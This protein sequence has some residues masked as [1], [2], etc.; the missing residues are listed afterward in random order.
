ML[1]KKSIAGLLAGIFC[2]FMLPASPISAEDAYTSDNPIVDTPEYAENFEMLMKMTDEERIAYV[3][4]NDPE[5]N[6]ENFCLLYREAVDSYPYY[7]DLYESLDYSPTFSFRFLMRDGWQYDVD[8]SPLPDILKIPESLMLALSNARTVNWEGSPFAYYNITIWLNPYQGYS[9]CDEIASFVA[10]L[11]AHPDVF[12][13]YAEYPLWDGTTTETTTSDTTPETTTLPET[14]TTLAPETTTASAAT[15][16]S[17]T[18]PSIEID[19]SRFDTLLAMDKEELCAATNPEDPDTY[20]S[21][22]E[23][24]NSTLSMYQNNQDEGDCVFQFCIPGGEAY[25]GDEEALAKLIGMPAELT[26]FLQC[27]RYATRDDVLSPIFSLHIK[28]TGYNGFSAEDVCITTMLMLTS[29]PDLTFVSYM[30]PMSEETTTATPETTTLPE[31]TTT[32]APETTTASAATTASATTAAATTAPAA[33]TT[34]TA[35]ASG[36]ASSPKTGDASAAA[37]CM[38]AAAAL[39]GMCL[40]RRKSK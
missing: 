26:V 19:T 30:P 25:D 14:T 36:A 15:T 13:V 5:E 39:A 40:C 20:L 6:I 11:C 17:A 28:N 24:Y 16:A 18:T 10:L 21:S 1:I 27:T 34:T 32:L 22:E 7:A 31:S 29:H 4:Q 3:A 9:Y 2:L 38:G 35:A 33:T 12:N 8:D 23:V 37:L